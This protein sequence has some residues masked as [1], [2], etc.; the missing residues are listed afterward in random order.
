MS[1]MWLFSGV[2]VVLRVSDCRS[3]LVVNI[4]LSVSG[5]SNVFRF[6][7]LYLSCSAGFCLSSNSSYFPSAVSYYSCFFVLCCLLFSSSCSL[8]CLHFLFVVVFMVLCCLLVLWIGPLRSPLCVIL[9]NCLFV[10]AFLF[11]MCRCVRIL[12]MFL[13]LHFFRAVFSLS[14]ILVPC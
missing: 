6:V 2:I 11:F 7:D 5:P 12:V 4:S 3:S 13:P 1:L 14:I 8:P 9:P 10:I